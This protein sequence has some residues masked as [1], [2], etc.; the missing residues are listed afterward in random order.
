MSTQSN[1]EKVTGLPAEPYTIDAEGVQYAVP[2]VAELF[3]ELGA[4]A[5]VTVTPPAE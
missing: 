2:A 4:V 1:D 5:L 3:A